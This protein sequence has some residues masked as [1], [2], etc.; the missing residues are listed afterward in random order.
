MVVLGMGVLWCA[1]NGFN[2]IWGLKAL[3]LGVLRV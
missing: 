2:G 1:E 3:Y